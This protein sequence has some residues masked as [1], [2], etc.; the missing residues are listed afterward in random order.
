[1]KLFFVRWLCRPRRTLRARSAAALLASPRRPVEHRALRAVLRPWRPATACARRKSTVRAD[2]LAFVNMGCRWWLPRSS[3]A[4]RA[5]R[6]LAA[7]AIDFATS[8]KAAL[9]LVAENI[10]QDYWIIGRPGQGL[11]AT[12]AVTFLLH[13]LRVVLQCHTTIACHGGQRPVIVVLEMLLPI[14][15]R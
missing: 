9:R 5:K 8:C 13:E 4:P 15:P 6:I 14:E 1:M 10:T 11:L 3:S 7:V 12:L 2:V